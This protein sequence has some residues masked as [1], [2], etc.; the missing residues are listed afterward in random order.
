MISNFN[1]IVLFLV[2]C[3]RF[4][5]QVQAVS[6][7]GTFSVEQ[8]AGTVLCSSGSCQTLTAL[9]LNI[10][11][12]EATSYSVGLVWKL[13]RLLF[14]TTNTCILLLLVW[15]HTDKRSNSTLCWRNVR[16]LNVLEWVSSR[17]LNGLTHFSS[18]TT[19]YSLASYRNFL[20]V[21]HYDCLEVEKSNRK[22]ISAS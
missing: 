21:P 14:V 4:P 22:P 8:T 17:T 11:R 12:P 9:F 18:F 7:G 16:L 2:G 1:C 19:S 20:L 5:L 15:V 6:P 13:F 10:W 3:G